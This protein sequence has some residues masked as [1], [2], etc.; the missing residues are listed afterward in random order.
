MRRKG[1][2]RP[3]LGH[4][5]SYATFLEVLIWNEIYRINKT[6][7]YQGPIAQ[8][9]VSTIKESAFIFVPHKYLIMCHVNIL[10]VILTYTVTRHLLESKSYIY[11]K[12]VLS[13]LATDFFFFF[14]FN[15]VDTFE[16][17]IFMFL[18]CI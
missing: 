15:T 12:K 5:G 13:Y 10:S 4:K 16:V 7:I 9:I 2:L 1:A 3:R 11:N 18:I 17:T 14:S 6:V 8:Y